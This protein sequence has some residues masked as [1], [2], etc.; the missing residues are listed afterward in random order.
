MPLIQD[1]TINGFCA[2]AYPWILTATP[3]I[4]MPDIERYEKITL[5]KAQMAGERSEGR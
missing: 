2:F 4:I 3:P 1:P 5:Q